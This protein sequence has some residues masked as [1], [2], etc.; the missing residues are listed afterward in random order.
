M[1][2]SRAKTVLILAFLVLN[3]LLSFQLWTSRN[4]LEAS[5]VGAGVAEVQQLMESKGV[6]L[7]AELPEGTPILREIT[8]EFDDSL[9][10]VAREMLK[11]PVRDEI[12]MENGA[13]LS[14]RIA[15]QLPMG[16]SYVLDV[17]QSKKDYYVYNQ[18]YQKYP[19]FEVQLELFAEKG[20]ITQYRQSLVEVVSPAP[21]DP[22]DPSILSSLTAVGSLTENYLSTGAV[23][24][25]VKLGYHGQ[26]YN[27]ETQVLAP[28]WRIMLQSGELYYVHAING[29][30][31]VP[32]KGK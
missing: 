6:K 13:L 19:M 12:R 5:K 25:D 10:S 15:R 18:A 28:F 30:V 4:E 21:S 16:E 26:L 14:E 22:K 8:V 29:A 24:T 3:V 23:I 31:E 20:F 27:S 9:R 1:D 7:E 11:D 32:Q 17:K 2:W